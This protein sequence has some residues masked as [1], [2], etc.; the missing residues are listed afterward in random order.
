MNGDGHLTAAEIRAALLAMR[1]KAS[2]RQLRALVRTVDR[3][4]D[5]KPAEIL[6]R[7]T[8]FQIERA[9]HCTHAYGPGFLELISC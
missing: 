1:L 6:L 4:R 2:D 3:A 7:N 5:G 9:A 8:V